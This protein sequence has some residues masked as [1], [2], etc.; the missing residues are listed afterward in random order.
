MKVFTEKETVNLSQQFIYKLRNLYTSD[1]DL[2]NQIKDYIPQ[3]YSINRRGSLDLVEYDAKGI[4]SSPEV[5]RL[6]EE[7][8]SYLPEICSKELL[9]FITAKVNTFSS[10]KTRF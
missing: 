3:N 8:A 1:L 7:G 9:D 4:G 5:V 2:F 6:I 10:I